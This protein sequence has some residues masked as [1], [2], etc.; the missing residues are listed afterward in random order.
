MGRPWR[1]AD[2]LSPT[3][4][5]GFEQVEVLREVGQVLAAGGTV[6]EVTTLVASD[7]SHRPC[8]PFSARVNGARL[9]GAEGWP[10]PP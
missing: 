6:A 1:A 4:D 3:D 5:C 7:T 2:P 10:L 8:Q 9:K